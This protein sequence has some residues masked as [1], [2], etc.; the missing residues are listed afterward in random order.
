MSDKQIDKMKQKGGF[1]QGLSIPIAQPTTTV[2]CCGGSTSSS[3]CGESSGGN[4]DCCGESAGGCCG[5]SA[6][7]TNISNKSTCCG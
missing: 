4:G 6:S 3:C 7:A 5:E 1:L 2:G